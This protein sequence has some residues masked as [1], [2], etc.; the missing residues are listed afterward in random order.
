[1]ARTIMRNSVILVDQMEQD[2]R[3][4]STPAEAIVEATVG[5]RARSC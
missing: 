3:A 4:S 1:M 5:G 2:I